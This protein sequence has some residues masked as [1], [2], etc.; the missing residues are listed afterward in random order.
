MDELFR[1]TL[2]E[3]NNNTR[4]S[5]LHDYAQHRNFSRY[6]H[7][8]FVAYL[9]YYLSKKLRL[10]NPEEIIRG[11][12]LHDYYFYGHDDNPQKHGRTH[13]AVALENALE[14]IPDLGE[15][16]MEIIYSHMFPLNIT[17]Y[18]KSKEAAI[19]MIADKI[20]AV[21]EAFHYNLPHSRGYQKM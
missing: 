14:D 5:E 6:E 21:C 19:V 11:G 4:F 8:L 3:L 1:N 16:E 2:E 10:D 20:C 17:R 12:L 15:K 9:S 13:A 18:P 7:C